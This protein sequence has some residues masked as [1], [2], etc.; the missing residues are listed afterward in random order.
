MICS[1]GAIFF[2]IVTIWTLV[3]G[4]YVWTPYAFLGAFAGFLIFFGTYAFMKSV[5]LGEASISTPIYRISFVITAIVAIFFL[6]EAMTLR[7]GLGFLFAGASIFFL[8]EFPLNIKTIP[9]ERAAS[10]FWALIAM[11]SLGFLNIVYKIG[12]SHGVAP[13]MLLHSQAIFFNIAVYIYA[14]S[15]QGGPRFSR[16]GW[17]HAA[18][19][20]TT[21]LTGLIALLAAFREGEASVV[22]PIAQL[23]F[24]VSALLATFLLKER[25]T[26]RKVVGLLLAIATITAFLPE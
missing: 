6:N 4:S 24:V 11:V 7:K 15:T 10:I 2:P 18:V 20:A 22:T 12:V 19:T 25:F 1:Q 13:T 3:E 26:K 9:K 5:Q 17:A 14:F 21:L 16:S 8:S 23:S